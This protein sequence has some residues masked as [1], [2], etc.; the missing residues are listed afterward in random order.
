MRISLPFKTSLFF[1]LVTGVAVVSISLFGYYSAGKML[2]NEALANL[3]SDLRRE[4]ATLGYA[5]NTLKEDVQFLTG[6]AAVQGIIR[7]TENEGFDEQENT[8]INVWENRMTSFIITLI[9]NRPSYHQIRFIS[10]AQEGKEILRVDKVGETITVTKKENLQSKGSRDYFKGIAQL[11]ESEI[12]ISNINY[13]REHGIIS[14]PLLPVLRV[15]GQVRKS[16]EIFGMIVINVDVRQFAGSLYKE[17]ADQF[18]FL[19]NEDG[20]FLI[21]P[22]ENKCLSFEF[23]GTTRVQDELKVEKGAYLGFENDSFKVMNLAKQGM[24]MVLHRMHFD[25]ND[26]NRFFLMGSVADFERINEKSL[27]LGKNLTY[28]TLGICLSMGVV[29]RFAVRSLT[30]PILQLKA[31]SDR[32][33]GGEEGVEI[34]ATSKDEVGELAKSM[35]SMVE[36]QRRAQHELGELAD[37]LEGK[38]KERTIE[39]ELL[40]K[41][42]ES[43]VYTISHDL[44]TPIVSLQGFT[45]LIIMEMGD[46]LP[47]DIKTYLGHMKDSI[48]MMG[49]L[50]EDLLEL[51]RVGRMDYKSENIEINDL[52]AQVLLE[53]SS[54]SKKRG[55]KLR[56]QPNLPPV[57]ANR[58]RVYQ[59]FSN[60]VGNAVKFMPDTVELPL[61]EI[62][63]SRGQNGLASFTV[64]DNGLGIDPKH[65]ERIFTMFQRLHGRNVPGTGMGLAL[66]KKIIETFGGSIWIESSKGSGASFHFT[67]PMA[68]SST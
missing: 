55:V 1:F 29:S 56:V 32:I 7:A 36:K 10:L 62:T 50:N 38:V 17:S 61:V 15:G 47:D 34:N 64:K 9:R 23:G 54:I 19:A 5:L 28:W 53:Q 63:S 45:N 40:N 25:D 39:L 21:H 43:F 49:Q 3:S 14:R 46:N 57:M 65:H 16:G 44:K 13:N 68:E 51:S 12:Y 22:D 27:S 8:M 30:R 35:A 60:L 18:F 33:A 2:Q 67:F 26:T 37:S 58:K 59:V 31:A 20:E 41:E 48:T 24:G 66:V 4:N 11:D 52:I 6:I 42:M